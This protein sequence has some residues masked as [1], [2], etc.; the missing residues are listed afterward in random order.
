ME[1]RLKHWINSCFILCI[2]EENQQRK[3]VVEKERLFINN[4]KLKIQNKI[5]AFLKD[6]EETH[7]QFESEDKILRTI[8]YVFESIFIHRVI[9]CNFDIVILVTEL[10]KMLVC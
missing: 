8:W 3:Q 9:C 10:P 1:V 6:S 4:Y 7:L 2:L 5:T